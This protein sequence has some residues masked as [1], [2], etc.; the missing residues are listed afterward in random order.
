MRKSFSTC[1]PQHEPMLS[2]PS[3]ACPELV[4]R[5]V[6]EEPVGR[7]LSRAHSALSVTSSVT[8]T[9]DS[10]AGQLLPDLDSLQNPPQVARALASFL[11]ARRGKPLW[12]WEDLSPR[13]T[14]LKSAAELELLLR[15]VARLFG[16]APHLEHRWAQLALHVAL[17]C[18]SRHYA[19]RSLQVFR[20]LKVPLSSRMLCELLS[21]LIETVAEQ[22]E[23]AQVSIG[24]ERSELRMP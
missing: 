20:A 8:L 6:S 13:V 12:Q 9:P 4:R 19:A 22:H 24:C 10:L 21:R 15:Y 1:S 11:L 7:P 18:A 2:P 16:E 5:S 14:G 23:D 17:S 3:D